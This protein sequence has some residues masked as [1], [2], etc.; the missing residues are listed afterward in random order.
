MPKEKTYR[1]LRF[2]LDDEFK[3]RTNIYSLKTDNS[4]IE[5]KR[6]RYIEPKQIEM[7]SVE[8]DRLLNKFLSVF[9]K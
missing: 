9:G 3:I 1:K 6:V 8:A 2:S 7:D 4:K 5:E